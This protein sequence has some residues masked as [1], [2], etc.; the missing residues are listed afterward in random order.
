MIFAQKHRAHAFVRL[1]QATALSIYHFALLPHACSPHPPTA[2]ATAHLLYTVSTHEDAR[3]LLSKK[4][5]TKEGLLQLVGLL[6]S[7]PLSMQVRGLLAYTL[8][9]QD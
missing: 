1:H 2:A 3:K 7:A 8:G 6:R 5:G 4:L 9:W